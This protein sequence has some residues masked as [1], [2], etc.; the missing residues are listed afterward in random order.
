V[1]SFALAITLSL[2]APNLIADGGG[3]GQGNG[4]GKSQG[5]GKSEG[6]GHD[7]GHGNKHHDDEQSW[8]KRQ[9]YEYRTYSVPGQYPPGWNHGKK[10]GWGNCGMPPGQA[11]KYGCRTY[12]YEGRPYY[13]YQNEGGAIIVRRPII[14]I[15]GGVTVAP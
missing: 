12:V 9:N 7:N 3:Q 6:N 8:E 11:K 2:G 13:Y 14:S 5:N 10:T 1:Y 15:Q 4:H